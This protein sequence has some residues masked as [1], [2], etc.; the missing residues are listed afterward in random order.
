[1]RD[2]QVRRYAR[3][4]LLP[5]VGG[6]GQVA[7]LASA[8]MIELPA[9]EPLAALIAA[10]YLAAGGV[11][12]VALR[13]A[14]AEQLAE[15]AAQVGDGRLETANQTLPSVSD[16]PLE[17]PARPAWWPEPALDHGGAT[18]EA[19]WRGGLAAV[20]WMASVGNL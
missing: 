12:T 2:E 15:V 11:G 17:L 9:E 18:A 5:D 1:M 6:R 10:R 19:Y 16:G 8:A 7:L 20:R 3:H 4:I 14:T 13:G